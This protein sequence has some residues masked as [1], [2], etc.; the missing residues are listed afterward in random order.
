MKHGK[1][2]KGGYFRIYFRVLGDQERDDT[3]PFQAGKRIGPYTA[4]QGRPLI[5]PVV[6][7]ISIR[8][9]VYTT[10]GVEGSVIH[11]G[12]LR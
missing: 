5:L 6:P 10:G 9:A 2:T 1:K 3:R 8:I 11:Y 4:K 7:I 12:V